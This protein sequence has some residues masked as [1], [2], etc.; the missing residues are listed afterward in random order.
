M[1]GYTGSGHVVTSP[2]A[3]RGGGGGGTLQL[4]VTKPLF[5]TS[6]MSL[7]VSVVATSLLV[8][9]CVCRRPRPATAPLRLR[10]RRQQ[11]A[12]VAAPPSRDRPATA[13]VRHNDRRP[14]TSSRSSIQCHIH[15]IYT[16]GQ[17]AF[18]ALT[19]LVGRQEGHPACKN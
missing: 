11:P 15:F 14:T 13:A 19:L 10:S 6:V 8:A 4:L 16:V 3:V 18:S 7:G 12:H 2:A 5:W 17:S 1:I 9:L